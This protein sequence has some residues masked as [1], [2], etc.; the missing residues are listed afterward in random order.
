MAHEII[1]DF[2]PHGDEPSF[3]HRVRNFGEDLFRLLE[4]ERYASISLNDV[5]TAT[6]QLRVSV[7]S[8]ARLGWTESEIGKLLKRHHLADSAR[9]SWKR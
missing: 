9:L 4:P 8:P 6:T 1:I 3:T 7:H 5:D 2:Q